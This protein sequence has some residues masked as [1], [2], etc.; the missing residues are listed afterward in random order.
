MKNYKE[1][2]KININED[3][4]AFVYNDGSEEQTVVISGTAA[5]LKKVKS[6]LPSGTKTINNVPDDVMEIPASEWL[7]LQ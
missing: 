4:L 3:Q 5:Q 2:I 7:K 1:F 6:K